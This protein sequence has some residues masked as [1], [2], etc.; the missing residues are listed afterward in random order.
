MVAWHRM[1]APPPGVS[2]VAGVGLRRRRDQRGMNLPQNGTFGA[3]NPLSTWN[4]PE[5]RRFV[6]G[7][8]EG[9]CFGIADDFVARVTHAA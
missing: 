1:G 7:S 9:T 4:V 6:G 3:R 2:G 8:L 5:S